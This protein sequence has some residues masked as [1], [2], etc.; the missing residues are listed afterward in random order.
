MR[1][2]YIGN[3]SVGHSTESHVAQAL[4]ALDIDVD[5]HQENHVDWARLHGAVNDV[6]FVLWTTTHDYA[7]PASYDSQRAFMR[8]LAVPIVGY[9]LDRW[10][11][12]EREHRI[13][14][15]PF[16]RCD[17]LCT[18]DGGHEDRWADARINHRWF[19]P[20]VSEFECEPGRYRHEYASEIAFVGSW[21][22]YHPEWDHR[23]QLIKFLRGQYGARCAMWPRRGEHAIRGSNLRDLYASVDILIGDS[24]LAG[25]AMNYWS[26]RIPET[27]GRGGFLVHPDVAGL[28]DSYIDGEHLVTW[29]LGNWGELHDTIEHY[30]N[31]PEEVEKI[32]QAGRAEVLANHTYTKRMA[33]LVA[34]LVGEDVI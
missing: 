11:G 13:R 19:A 30:L 33:D 25:D 34:L 9:H 18:A 5:R 26:D 21:Q 24:C 32:A 28:E 6:D 8:R 3:F 7:P 12:L 17:V 16:F 20:A 31:H 14:E 22:T 2:A 29:Q 4:E 1:V 27:L 15:A 23:R 10:W